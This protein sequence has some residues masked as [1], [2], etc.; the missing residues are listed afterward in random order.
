MA[1]GD[2]F[3]LVPKGEATKLARVRIDFPNAL[4]ESWTIDI[5]KSRARPPHAVRERLRQIIA[6]ITDRST[7]VHRGRGQKLFQEVEAPLWERYADSGGIRFEVNREHPLV[8]SLR[9]KLDDAGERQLLM[10][11]ESIGHALPV[12]MIYS[13]YSLHP[14]EFGSGAVEKEELIRRLEALRV[15]LYGPEGGNSAGFRDV[16]KSIRIFE[17]RADIL[18][19]YISEHFY[20]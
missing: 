5:K 9:S 3:R 18:E 17:N 19:N 14:K 4:D 15:V 20:E 10:L 13:D 2:W 12:E 11:V 8:L 7:T 16:A 6:K 1:W